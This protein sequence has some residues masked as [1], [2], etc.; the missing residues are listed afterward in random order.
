MSTDIAVPTPGL[1]ER[2]Q[3]AMD[4]LTDRLN[5]IT[6]ALTG[7]NVPYALVGGQAVIFWVSTKDPAAVR[8]TRDVDILIDRADLAKAK[9][10]ALAA[11]LEYVEVVDVGMFVEPSDP[12]PKHGVNLV[13]AGEKV[14]A[15][16]PLPTPTI[17]ERQELEPG[18]SVVTLAGLVRMKLTANR[19]KD[20]VHL[21]DMIDVGLI[22][23]SMLAG[24]P[25]ELAARLDALLADAGR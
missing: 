20:R 18:K 8:T 2:Y 17:A 15:D 5:R 3:M 10:A 12:N 22:D 24:L 23:R 6:A 21:R 1:W 16:D 13:W 14:K 4:K 9:S 25:D 7:M 11:G 19:D